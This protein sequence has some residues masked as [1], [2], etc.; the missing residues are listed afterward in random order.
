MQKFFFFCTIC[1]GFSKAG[2]DGNS[3]SITLPGGLKTLLTGIGAY[4]PDGRE[5]QRVGLRTNVP[6]CPTIVGLQQG[7]DELHERAVELILQRPAL[8][9]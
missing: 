7:R 4:Y 1:V 9:P 6:V 8:V 2:A 3:T 5:T